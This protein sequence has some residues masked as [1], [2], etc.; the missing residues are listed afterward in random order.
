MQHSAYQTSSYTVPAG[1]SLIVDRFASFL[2]CL[3]ASHLFKIR[4]GTG[5]I[6]DFEAGLRMRPGEPFEKVE[7]INKAAEPLAVKLGFGQGDV[8]DARLT[9]TT[10]VKTVA[11]GITA[12]REAAPDDFSVAHVTALN[13]GTTLLS[14]ADENRRELLIVNTHD[15]GIV[16]VVDNAT[17]A[18]H[19]I[20]VLPGQ[21]ITLHTAAAVYVRNDSGS[22]VDVAVASLG[23]SA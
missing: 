7:L 8:R 14:G 5:P 19:G 16:Q 2:I 11:Q 12:T 9:I 20:P 10:D 21:S 13:G 4:L 3:E 23:W 1:G 22:S 15:A 17:A 18:G 6:S